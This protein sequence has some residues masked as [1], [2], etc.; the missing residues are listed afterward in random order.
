LRTADLEIFH[1]SFV[2][3]DNRI[4]R[5]IDLKAIVETSRSN[6]SPQPHAKLLNCQ[7]T[8]CTLNIA[9]QR[10]AQILACYANFWQNITISPQVMFGNI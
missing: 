5:N 3:F 2:L 10:Y 1:Y 6:I 8:S 9:K 7:A 4:E